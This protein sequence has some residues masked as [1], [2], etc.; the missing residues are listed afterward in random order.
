MIE[1]PAKDVQGFLLY[2]FDEDKHFFRV[3]GE[4]D[5]KTGRKSF[6]DYDLCA[7]DIQITITS[8]VASLFDSESDE[9][10]E[11]GKVSWASNYSYKGKH[12]K[13]E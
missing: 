9:P 2:D 6:K 11:R 4:I 5:P 7:E 3:Y 1:K 10:F 8:N 12:L 13:K